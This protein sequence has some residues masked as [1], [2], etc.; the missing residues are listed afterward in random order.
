MHLMSP[1]AD[2]RYDDMRRAIERLNAAAKPCTEANIA[3]ELGVTTAELQAPERQL[4]SE[5]RRIENDP[6]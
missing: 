5:G 3:A 1:A 6:E 2:E 4:F